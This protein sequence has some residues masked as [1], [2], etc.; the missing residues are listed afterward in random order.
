MLENE[1]RKEL[2]LE[3]REI[4]ELLHSRD[5]KQAMLRLLDK[6]ESLDRME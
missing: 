4:G 5:I 6:H 3:E 1:A 2:M